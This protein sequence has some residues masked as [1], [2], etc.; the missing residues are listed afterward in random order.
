MDLSEWEQRFGLTDSLIQKE[1]VNTYTIEAKIL[2]LLRSRKESKFLPQYN[3][4]IYEQ[5]EE[6]EK[7]CKNVKKLINNALDAYKN[8]FL[9]IPIPK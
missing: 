5:I 1:L 8:N 2:Y 6:L 4:L 7:S 9:A 3:L